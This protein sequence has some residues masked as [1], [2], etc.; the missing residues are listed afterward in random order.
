MG[1]PAKKKGNGAPGGLPHV[2]NHLLFRHTEATCHSVLPPH[3]HTHNCC[4]SPRA[5]RRPPS[6]DAPVLP[7]TPR[8][9][10]TSCEF[11]PPCHHPHA[12]TLSRSLVHASLVR[13]AMPTTAVD[14]IRAARLSGGRVARAR[15]DVQAG[16][17][18]RMQ[19]QFVCVCD[20]LATPWS[21]APPCVRRQGHE[22]HFP[23]SRVDKHT[24]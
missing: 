7:T 12:P 4:S 13:A 15:P 18:H 17:R 20:A 24:L 6:P 19:S 5:D 9:T 16:L 3:A 23:R 8:V 22:R 21:A 11:R 2:Q 14:T 10:F 1:F